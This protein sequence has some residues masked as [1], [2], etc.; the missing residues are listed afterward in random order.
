MRKLFCLTICSMLAFVSLAHGEEIR[1]GTYNVQHWASKFDTRKLAEWA[2]T[3]PRSD[4]LNEMV[5]TER[6]QD[7][8]DNWM[9]ATT[10][11]SPEFNP[12]IMFFQEGC[13]QEDLEY[14]NKKWL[15]GAY[16]TLLVFP[17]N[18]GRDQNVGMM[19]K[20]GFKV[21]E[22]RDQYYLEKD[23]VPKDFLKGDYD[24]PAA[25]ENRLF[26]RGP[27]FV[28]VQSPSGYVFWVGTNHQ[29]SKSGNNL[30]VTKWRNREAAR[31]HEIIKEIEKAGPADVVFGGDLNDEL[32]YQ[33][34]E[35]QAGGDSIAM[36]VG[37]PE[38]GIQCVT[39]PLVDKGEISFGGYFNDRYRSFIDHMFVTRSLKDRVAGVSVIRSG[40]AP[41][42]SDH[43]PVLVRITTPTN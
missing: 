24:G 35:Q 7:D 37:A 29:K 3:Q 6:N 32:G 38:A 17:S 22:K 39:K 8:K 30:D 43:Y 15:K 33:E 26:A 25:A 1:I 11:L 2:K 5:R 27:A 42:A 21:L 20:P 28:K 13:N 16:E 9:V 40:V 14:F 36:I 19:L 18:S 31:L 10:I 41:A 4:E 12:D 23:S 34:F